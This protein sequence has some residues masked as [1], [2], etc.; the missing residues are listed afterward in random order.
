M[1]ESYPLVPNLCASMASP[2]ERARPWAQ[3][4]FRQA[5]LRAPVSGATGT[6]SST[7]SKLAIGQGKWLTALLGKPAKGKVELFNG[8][9]VGPISWTVVSAVHANYVFDLSGTIA[10]TLW[11]G[12]AMDRYHYA[13]YLRLYRSVAD[14]SQ[15]RY[16]ISERPSCRLFPNPA[17]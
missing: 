5:L 14:R 7:G 1:P 15:R 11:N 17:H 10:G 16:P 12:M 8:S 2:R 4:V 6:F 3:S 9:F 13:D